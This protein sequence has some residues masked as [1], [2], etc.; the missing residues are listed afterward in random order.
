MKEHF[1]DRWGVLVRQYIRSVKPLL[2]SD[3]IENAEF[4][5]QQ[6]PIYRTKIS[7][8]DGEKNWS[9]FAEDIDEV[10]LM[11]EMGVK[12][13]VD[14]PEPR[15]FELIG[16]DDVLNK[17]QIQEEWYIDL[18]PD[19]FGPAGKS[20]HVA[21]NRGIPKEAYEKAVETTDE[22]LNQS[23]LG[24]SLTEGDPDDGFLDL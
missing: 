10:R 24:L 16:L 12:P 17:Q 18:R 7:P 3:E 6:V 8:P 20:D 1:S 9:R 5:R 4:Y 11:R 13:G 15:T 19:E 23:G 14:V 22:F 2:T 21:V